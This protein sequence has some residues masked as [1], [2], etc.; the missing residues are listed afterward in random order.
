[1]RL[2]SMGTVPLDALMETTSTMRFPLIFPARVDPC[3]FVG[4]IFFYFGLVAVVYES[5]LELLLYDAEYHVAGA[6]RTTYVY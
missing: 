6:S 5:Y 4:L 2:P 1:M 3:H